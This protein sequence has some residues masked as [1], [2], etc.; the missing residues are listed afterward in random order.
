MHEKKITMLSVDVGSLYGLNWVGRLHLTTQ[1]KRRT[2]HYTKLK[3][4]FR[5][6]QEPGLFGEVD[7]RIL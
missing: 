3:D 2:M 1:S 7:R 5:L 4:T 6:K